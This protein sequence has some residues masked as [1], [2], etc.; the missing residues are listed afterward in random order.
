MRALVIG[1]GP[2]GCVAVG[3]QLVDYNAGTGINGTFVRFDNCTEDRR[4]NTI[5][6]AG[7]GCIMNLD[8][9]DV[10]AWNQQ[11]YPIGKV[12]ISDLVIRSLSTTLVKSRRIA[13]DVPG[14]RHA[15]TIQI[16]YESIIIVNLSLQAR[17]AA[18]LLC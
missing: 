18:D 2:G 10:G 17:Q 12:H 13:G 7:E 8:S 3:Q 1:S 6:A 11:V 4:S 15:H 9:Q 5:G 14:V 16:Q